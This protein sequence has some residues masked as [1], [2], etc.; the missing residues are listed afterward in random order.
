VRR[1]LKRGIRFCEHSHH[2]PRRPAEVRL[3]HG[4]RDVVPVD[5]AEFVAQTVPD[6]H[7]VIWADEGHCGFIRRWDQVLEGMLEGLR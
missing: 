2:R 1:F 6:G 7:L 4:E 5:R 3:W